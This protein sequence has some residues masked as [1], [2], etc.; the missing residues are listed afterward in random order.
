MMLLSGH[1]QE[2]DT[3]VVDE[4]TDALALHVKQH[5]EATARTESG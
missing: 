3:I 4:G 5:E 1:V 2:G